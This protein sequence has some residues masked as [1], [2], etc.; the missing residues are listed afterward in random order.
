MITPRPA[1]PADLTALQDI[2]QLF[3][4]DRLS[5]RQMRY[6][7]TNPRALFLVAEAGGKP[8]GY[9]LFFLRRNRAARFYSLIVDPARRGQGIARLLIEEGCRRL[10]AQGEQK[11]TLEVDAQD[12]TTIDFYARCGFL[13]GVVIPAYYEDGRDALKMTK[14]LLS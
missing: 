10:Y 14:D 3:P 11:V 9:A 7:L 5:A 1:L 6:H 8:A 2:E 13:P 12:K 4:S